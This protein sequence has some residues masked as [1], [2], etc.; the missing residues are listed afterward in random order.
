[1]GGAPQMGAPPMGG[2]PQ[3]GAPQMGYTPPPAQKSS[4]GKGCLI[5]FAIVFIIGIIA[6]VVIVFAVRNTVHDAVG[7][8]DCPFLSNGDAS[9]ALGGNETVNQFGGLTSFA[10]IAFDDRV[11]P[12]A[13]SCVVTNTG[14]AT[15]GGSA[16]AVK[17]DGGDA[18]SQYQAELTKAK[19]SPSSSGAVTIT[20]DGYYLKDVTMG[21]EAFCTKADLTN[22]S[23]GVLVHKG[24]TLVYVSVLE[25]A[26][27]SGTANSDDANCDNAQKVASKILG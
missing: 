9:A 4:G 24:N 1:M 3:M 17:Y 20:S 25:S 6:A 19:G 23:G 16:R 15:S 13:P 10:N 26:N 27:A 5:A 12:N 11:L 2:A 14:G 18:A 7:V 8:N 21:D 22:P